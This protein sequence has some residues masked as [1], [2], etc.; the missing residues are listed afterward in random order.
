MKKASQVWNGF[1]KVDERQVKCKLCDDRPSYH[2]GT[3]S[4]LS[5]IRTKHPTVS[6]AQQTNQLGRVPA[7]LQSSNSSSRPNQVVPENQ[8]GL[9]T[10]IAKMVALDMMPTYMVE[11]K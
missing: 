6:Q 8:P 3:S 2:S 5:H 11:G 1:E 7:S 9:T 10:L 4:M